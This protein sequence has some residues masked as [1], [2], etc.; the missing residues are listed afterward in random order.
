M[1]LRRGGGHIGLERAG[2][3]G[4]G[5]A[6]AAA[7]VKQLSRRTEFVAEEIGAQI[8]DIQQAVPETGEAAGALVGS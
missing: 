4:H 8:H 5:F 7:A 1:P 2:E 3:T 6:V